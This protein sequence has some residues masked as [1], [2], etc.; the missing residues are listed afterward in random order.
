MVDLLSFI[1]DFVV[2]PKIVRKMSQMVKFSN[3]KYN[4]CGFV[5][6]LV[7]RGRTIIIVVPQPTRKKTN[8]HTLYFVIVELCHLPFE[9]FS[10]LYQSYFVAH[11][12]LSD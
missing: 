9:T 10:R 2:W 8:L 7:G 1:K 6:F 5:F 4:V 3:N 11:L 12:M